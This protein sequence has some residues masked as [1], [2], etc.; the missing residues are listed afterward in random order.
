MH[1]IGP[2][3]AKGV[4]EVHYCECHIVIHIL[5]CRRVS[6]V[7]GHVLCACVCIVCVGKWVGRWMGRWMGGWV[8][9]RG[10]AMCVCECVCVCIVVCVCSCVCVCV[11]VCVSVCVRLCVGST[12]SRTRYITAYLGAQ[13]RT[14]RHTDNRRGTYERTR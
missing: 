4:F 1:A 3:E 14:V 12:C 2:E 13:D 5:G 8:C 11:C 10:C 6:T 7:G 9:V